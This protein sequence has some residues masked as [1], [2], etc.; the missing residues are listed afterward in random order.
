M[1]HD[2][3]STCEVLGSSTSKTIIYDVVYNIWNWNYRGWIW[4]D[5]VAISSKFAWNTLQL[6]GLFPYSTEGKAGLLS[7]STVR[8]SINILCI[9]IYIKQQDTGKRMRTLEAA[10]IGKRK[11]LYE[12]NS[13]YYFCVI[14][15]GASICEHRRRRIRCTVCR[16]AK[17]VNTANAIASF[18]FRNLHVCFCD[19]RN[20]TQVSATSEEVMP[21]SSIEAPVEPEEERSAPRQDTGKLRTLT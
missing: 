20:R 10:H 6:S 9:S 19:V 1:K 16:D 18:F 8:W 11:R 5:C 2:F 17:Q 13:F 4:T 3:S 14:C 7:Y 12:H 15:G 21:F